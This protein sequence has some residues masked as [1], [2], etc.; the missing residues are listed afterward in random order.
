VE[1]AQVFSAKDRVDHAQFG[2]GTILKIDERYTTIEF[3][4]S[5]TRKFVTRMVELAPTDTPKPPRRRKTAKKKTG[6]SA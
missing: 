1:N 3:D 4:E 5:G 6:Q 2:L